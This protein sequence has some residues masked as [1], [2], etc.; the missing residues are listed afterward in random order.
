MLFV[1]TNTFEFR[2]PTGTSPDLIGASGSANNGDGN[3]RNS[4]NKI[5]QCK[6][7]GEMK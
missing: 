4:E 1:D 6:S 5:R 2:D 7:Y 3:A